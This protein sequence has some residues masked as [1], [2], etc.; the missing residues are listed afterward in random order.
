M[1]VGDRPYVE[2]AAAAA[3]G[4]GAAGQYQYRVK[5]GATPNT[6]SRIVVNQHPSGLTPK[7]LISGNLGTPLI[8]QL[9]RPS[10][11]RARVRTAQPRPGGCY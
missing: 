1:R 8:G 11:S 9:G 7:I 2:L 6:P 4:I 5:W 3:V 10:Y